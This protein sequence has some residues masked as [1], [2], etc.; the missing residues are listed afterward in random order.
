[1]VGNVSAEIVLSCWRQWN[2]CDKDACLQ[3]LA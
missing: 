2:Q 3:L 1:M